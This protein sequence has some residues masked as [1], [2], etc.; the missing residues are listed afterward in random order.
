MRR[1][2]AAALAA[3]VLA[4][5]S[6]VAA[7]PIAIPLGPGVVPD[8]PEVSAAAWILYDA[9]HDVVLAS[10]SEDEVRAMASTTKMMTA[11]LAIEHG[12][13]DDEVRISEN[14][15]GI[16]EAEV[17]LEAGETLTVRQL[18]TALMIRSA[19]DA[20]IA[21]AEHVAG[22]EAAFVE[23]MNE[24]ARALGLEET[25]FAN[26]HGLDAPGHHSSA[27][28]LL[29]LA[30]VA[31]QEPLFAELARTRRA[32]L[33]PDS[34]GVVR[35]VAATNRLLDD[36]EGLIGVKT[37]FTGAAGLCL[38]SAATRDGRTLYAVVLGSEAHFADTAAL[39]DHGFDDFRIYSAVA[40]GAEFGVR[41]TGS[42]TVPA[43][44]E[45]E[46]TVMG[47]ANLE[48]TL[49]PEIR[50]GA[51]AIVARLGGEEI[52]V[53]AVDA[54]PGGGLPGLLDALRWIFAR[55]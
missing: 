53:T 34:T 52:G 22:S 10:E 37:G 13:L 35:V 14:A 43:V 46:V 4:A 42:E 3:I 1:V 31:M 44:A 17:D 50:D 6:A 21:V 19:N 40:A 54:G 48:L 2:L 47:D 26:P 16:G 23:M 30:R 39:L 33:P 28:D 11:L 32:V 24:R 55:P 12:G 45:E 36:Y 15:A 8:P 41:R 27:R 20:S 7:A 9:T 49:E 38:V 29:T 51:P 18:V 25:Q 5:P